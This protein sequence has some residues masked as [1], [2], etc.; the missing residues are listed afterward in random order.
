M[1]FNQ[2]DTRYGII[3][4]R[5]AEQITAKP[6]YLF[7]PPELGVGGTEKL[8]FNYIDALSVIHP[9]WRIAV[10]GKPHRDYVK[11]AH[12]NVDF[13]D[14]FGLTSGLS[15]Y[16]KDILWSRLLVQMEVKKLHIIN[17]DW[18]Y[19]WISDHQ[20]LLIHEKYT[21]NASMFMREYT[22]EANRIRSYADPLLTDIYPV[23]NKVF[24][25]NQ[26]II[27]E[28]LGN[29][30]FDPAKLITHYQPESSTVVPVKKIEP[31]KPLR[32]LWAGRLS[33][34][35][36]PDLLKSIGQHIDNKKFH[37]DVYGTGSHYDGATYFKDTKAITYKGA[38]SGVNSIPTEKYDAFLYTSSVDGLPNILLEIASKGLPIVASDDGGVS[39]FILHE[40]TGLLVDIEDIKGY[41]DAL[42]LIRENPE[43]SKAYAEES[44]KLLKSRHS[45]DEFLT[46]VKRDL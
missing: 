3:Y 8:L 37:I 21:V 39:E 31:Q 26:N 40:S 15:K 10:I 18:F 7:L 16:E 1:S 29:N 42:N 20:N 33:K 46:V 13:I 22:E 28:M 34:Q 11:S 30:A 45:F 4:K 25:D 24:T 32:I 44:Q 2:Y 27:N 9:G 35:K 14:F 6:D 43:K 36:R 41:V 17:N 19:E 38:F 5:L 23:I 12:S